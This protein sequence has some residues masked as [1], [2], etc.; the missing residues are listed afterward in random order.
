VGSSGLFGDR[1][2]TFEGTFG[3]NGCGG[4]TRGDYEPGWLAYPMNFD[5]LFPDYQSNTGYLELRFAPDSD[6][7][8][9][10]QGSIVRVTG[11]FNDPASS[12][13][14]MSTFDGERAVSVDPRTAELL[15]RERFV[16][17]AYEVIGNDPHF[18]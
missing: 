5:W 12:T 6:L 18:P 7:E 3:C 8:R 9:P 15:C 10:E 4:M 1:S 17:D 16:V 2:L 13:C 11:H 14:T